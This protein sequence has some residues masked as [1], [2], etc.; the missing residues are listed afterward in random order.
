MS[1]SG[2][3]REEEQTSS[4]PIAG[5]I[6]F[7]RYKAEQAFGVEENTASSSLPSSSSKNSS[8]KSG[9]R[10]RKRKKKKHQPALV[11][12]IDVTSGLHGSIPSNSDPV[13]KIF[14]PQLSRQEVIHHL[15][16]IHLT[17]ILNNN[18]RSVML[19]RST[20]PSKYFS[21][22]TN[23]CVIMKIIKRPL[24]DP[25][26]ES[27]KE[28]FDQSELEYMNHVLYQIDLEKH[29]AIL[30]LEK[31]RRLKL[32][33]RTTQLPPINEPDDDQESSSILREGRFNGISPNVTLNESKFLY[34]NECPGRSFRRLDPLKSESFP[35]QL[36]SI[37]AQFSPIL[38][39]SGRFLAAGI[40]QE[41]SDQFLAVSSSK[42]AG[43]ARE[44]TGTY[45]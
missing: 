34:I 43:K 7:L 12:Y 25:F 11:L 28:Y 20:T 39:S 40:A 26:P 42:F 4:T 41:I 27:I 17:N 16:P 22:K 31:N 9:K 45:V 21:P 13:E 14:L 10:K 35:V 1:D 37:P 32:I 44:M 29:N 15:L 5:K 2:S 24:T 6:Y 3:S 8:N 33:N 38:A 36:F 23:Y 30:Q 19:T 18:R